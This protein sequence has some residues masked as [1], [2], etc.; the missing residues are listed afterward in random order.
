MTGPRESYARDLCGEGAPHVAGGRRDMNE[1]AKKLDSPTIER[2]RWLMRLRPLRCDD[3]VR[4]EDSQAHHG[5]AREQLVIDVREE[6]KPGCPKLR[7]RGRRHIWPEGPAGQAFQQFSRYSHCALAW[8]AQLGQCSSH[9]HAL[10]SPK[11]THLTAERW[12][13]LFIASYRS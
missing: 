11:A 3:Q 10:K 6:A 12:L 9:C 2:D 7:K 4:F 8:Q 1:V 13:A 5:C